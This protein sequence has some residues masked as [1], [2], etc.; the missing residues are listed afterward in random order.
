[1]SSRYPVAQMIA[2]TH[3]TLP[4]LNVTRVPST[5]AIA[6]RQVIAPART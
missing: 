5:A 2:S 3:S 1:M 4:S 6:G